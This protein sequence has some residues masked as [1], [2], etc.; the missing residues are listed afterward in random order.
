[1]STLKQLFLSILATPLNMLAVLLRLLK[2]GPL[3]PVIFSG[4]L[5]IAVLGGLW[6][7]GTLTEW[8][9]T[10]VETTHQQ[11]AKL[12]LAVQEVTVSGRHNTRQADLIAA[13]DAPLGTPIFKVDV[14]E[15]RQRLEA[16]PWVKTASVSRILPGKFHIE[17]TE[18]QPF[19][20]WQ[21]DEGMFVIDR[22]GVVIAGT[23]LN[24]FA[25]LVIVQGDNSNV[26]AAGFIDRLEVYPDL[27]RRLVALQRHGDR[28]WTIFLNHGGAIHLPADNVD[29]ALNKLMEM[30]R[31][32][33]ILDL[34]GYAIDLRLD[35]KMMLRPTVGKRFSDMEGNAI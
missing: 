8:Q 23:G 14:A 26:H 21:L 2:S 12:G 16:L 9:E 15:A 19:A 6:M 31:E 24:R 22:E 4:A 7:N 35:N 27:Y 10:V 1:M 30:E 3:M 25:D 18:R 17:L 32:K 11:M 5:I 20:K 28:R 34:E 13:F 29:Q 33:S